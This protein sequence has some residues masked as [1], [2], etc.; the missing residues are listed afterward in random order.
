MNPRDQLVA[1][2]DLDLDAAEAHLEARLARVEHLVAGLDAGHVGADRGDDARS[3]TATAAAAEAGRIRPARVS[4]SSAV[5]WMTRYSSSG[6]SETSTRLGSCTMR[7]RYR[8]TSVSDFKSDT[9]RFYNRPAATM[10]C[11]NCCV[12]SSRGAPKICSGGPS[13]RIRPASRKHTRCRDVAGEAHLVRRDQHRHAA[14]RELADHVEHL[15]D[16]L[17]VERARDLVEEEKLRLHREGAHDRDALLLAA[18]EPVGVLVPLV[19]EPEALEQARSRPP[20]PRERDSPSALRGAS[21][22]FSSTVMCGKRLNDW[23]TIPIPRRT[24]STST[25]RAVISSPPTTIRPGLR[26]ARAG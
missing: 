23:K 3:G 9:W 18:R 7:E 25:P 20:P 4:V 2:H 6:S 12:R 1:L 21:V 15:R 17:R 22:T 26:S 19:R 16:E 8:R 14:R 10:R 13:S 5:G 11:R 24:T